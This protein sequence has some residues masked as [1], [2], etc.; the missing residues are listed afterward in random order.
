MKSY[1]NLLKYILANGEVH[2]DRTGIGTISVFGYEWRHDMRSGFPLLTTKQLP[3]RIIFEELMWFLRGDTNN[4]KLLEKNVTIWNEWSTVEKCAKFNRR[5]GD[6][7]PIYGWQWRRFGQDYNPRDVLRPG[8]D[9]IYNLLNEIEKNPNSRRLIVTGWHP[10]QVLQVELP[11][12][13]TLWQIKCNDK[14]QMSLRLDARSI[15]AFLGL[16]FNIASYA[17]LL[18]MLCI[19]CGY[20]AKELIIQFGDLHIY[21]NHIEQVELQLSRQPMDLPKLIFN[22]KRDHMPFYLPYLLE[23]Q[24]EEFQLFNYKYHPKIPA[25]VAI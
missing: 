7:G 25:P 19:T 9:Q 23:I 8:F 16:P 13:H 15:D 21:S 11:P 10:K 18:E 12:C 17:L 5:E 14:R 4:L 22:S 6:L 24:F 20:E 1:I 2:N 3:L